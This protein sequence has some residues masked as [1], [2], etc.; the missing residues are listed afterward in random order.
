MG[1][2]IRTSYKA[3]AFGSA[4]CCSALFCGTDVAQATTPAAPHG[5]VGNVPTHSFNGQMHHPQAMHRH[6]VPQG[7]FA[8]EGMPVYL[9]GEFPSEPYAGEDNVD[10]AGYGGPSASPYPS[11]YPPPYYYQRIARPPPCVTPLVIELRKEPAHAQLPKVTYG[12]SLGACPPPIV[13]AKH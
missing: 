2:Q 4:L 8:G 3:I 7:Q 10:Y 1:A 11:P 6:H 5:F 12:S 13:E 9:S